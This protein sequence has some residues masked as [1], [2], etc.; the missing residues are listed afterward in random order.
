MPPHQREDAVNS[1]A[2]EAEARMKDPVYGCVGAISVLQRQVIR[3]Q[4]ELDATNA[5]LVRYACG[6]VPV[7][8]ATQPSRKGG[9]G[10]N[11]NYGGYGNYPSLWGCGGNERGE[12]NM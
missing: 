6:E 8:A 12:G 1:L 7:A 5:D 4:K 3:L 11:P 9:G 2:Y 10:F